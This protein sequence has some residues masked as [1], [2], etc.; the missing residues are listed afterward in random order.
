MQRLPW[1]KTWLLL[2][3][4]AWTIFFLT[5]FF[6]K[7][8]SRIHPIVPLSVARSATSLPLSVKITWLFYPEKNYT[9]ML[10]IFSRLSKPNMNLKWN[11]Y[12]SLTKLNF[13]SLLELTKMIL[14]SSNRLTYSQLQV[15]LSWSSILK[16]RFSWSVYHASEK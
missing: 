2:K 7:W 8:K 14:I 9:Y 1:K 16:T 10:L 6:C 12:S 3:T 5:G 15:G 11:K 13:V 4:T